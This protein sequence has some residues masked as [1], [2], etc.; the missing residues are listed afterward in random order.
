MIDRDHDL[1]IVQQARLLGL[2]RTRRARWRTRTWRGCAGSMPSTWSCRSR[3]VACSAIC[4]AAKARR[5]V[6]YEEVSLR[7]YETVSDVRTGRR[8]YVQFFNAR[9][10]HTA[11][12]G[13]TPDAAYF[14]PLSTP[15][16]VTPSGRVPK[17]AA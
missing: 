16:A 11:H 5:S 3:G 8:R 2:S 1:A 7:A 15:S 13:R 14:T 10:P 9:R 4:C 12:A 6:K 17:Q